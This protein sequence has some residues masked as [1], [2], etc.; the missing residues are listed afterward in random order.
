MAIYKPDVSTENTPVALSEGTKQEIPSA[1]TVLIKL[2]RNMGAD[3]STPGRTIAFE[4]DMERFNRRNPYWHTSDA[5]AEVRF[6]LFDPKDP[7]RFYVF[8]PQPS[9]GNGY[10]EMVY[11]TPPPVIAAIDDPISVDDIYANALLDYMLYRIYKIEAT[12][13]P[14]AP[15]KSTDHWNMFVTALGRMDLVKQLNS[16]KQSEEPDHGRKIRQ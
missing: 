16:P 3:G 1:G 8:P 6:F 11:A 15:A 7:R 5:S 2:T 10:V 14:Y 4:P 13:N 9:S 12:I